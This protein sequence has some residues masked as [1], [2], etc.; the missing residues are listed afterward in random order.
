M[1]TTFVARLP[2]A[3]AEALSAAIDPMLEELGIAHTLHEVGGGWEV[4]V[5]VELDAVDAVETALRRVAPAGAFGRGELP[6]E[7]WVTLSLRALAPVRAGGF[8]VHGSHDP[9]ARRPGETAI[10]VDANRAF[11]TGHHGTTAGCLDAIDRHLKRSRPM[12]VLDLGTGTGVLAIALAKRL[13]RPVLATDI[14]PVAVAIARANAR[15]NGVGAL[16]R[17]VTA[18]GTSHPAI[19]TGAPFDLIVANILAGPLRAMAPGIVR[20]LAPGGT[21]VLSG[22]LERQRASVVA[23]YAAQDVALRDTI[24]REGWATLT[25]RRERRL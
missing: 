17:V 1:T 8:V 5:Y 19:R 15:G 4:A 3:E 13:R 21:I 25:L 14:D 7:D 10:L 24:G 11:G 20:V 18:T 12:R 9:D 6:D 22:L 23:A 2:Q 16:V